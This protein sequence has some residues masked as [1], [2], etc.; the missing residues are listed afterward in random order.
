M[1]CC[2]CFRKR[3]YFY[4]E[5]TELK[6]RELNCIQYLLRKIFGLY[7]NTHNL[8][9]ILNTAYPLT[10]NPKVHLSETTKTNLLKLFARSQN[11]DRVDAVESP[12]PNSYIPIGS[13][14]NGAEKYPVSALYS[15]AR[16]D[17]R[18][19]IERIFFRL[20]VNETVYAFSIRKQKY[21]NYHDAE[22]HIA[23][24]TGMLQIENIP[25]DKLATPSLTPGIVTTCRADVDRIQTLLRT[26]VKMQQDSNI[27]DLKFFASLT[28]L[29]NSS[30]KYPQKQENLNLLTHH[31]FTRLPWSGSSR[32]TLSYELNVSYVREEIREGKLILPSG[33][34][35][36]LRFASE[37]L[38]EQSSA[39]TIPSRTGLNGHRGV[40]TRLP[41]H[42]QDGLEAIEEEED[43]NVSD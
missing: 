23:L 17:G 20:V 27:E 37:H 2:N 11:R 7:K 1:R 38:W 25:D 21:S 24:P 43:G 36:S 19:R 9:R 35:L 29:V 3:E 32:D 40:S 8:N 31:I 41:Q 5:G 4:F 33:T 6:A 18:L 10:F 13:V 16:T 39:P 12:N 15:M 34:P 30:E 26:I 28:S 42:S 14:N 22:L